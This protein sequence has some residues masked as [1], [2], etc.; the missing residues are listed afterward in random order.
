MKRKQQGT[1]CNKTKKAHK[2]KNVALTP[3]F[4]FWLIDQGLVSLIHTT[5]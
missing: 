1:K 2:K 4:K 3:E 5:K